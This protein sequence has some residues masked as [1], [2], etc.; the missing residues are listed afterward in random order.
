VN[1]STRCNLHY[2]R[3]NTKSFLIS[4]CSHHH[5]LSEI[6]GSSNITILPSTY[7]TSSLSSSFDAGLIRNRA[8]K[9]AIDTTQRFVLQHGAAGSLFRRATKFYYVSGTGQTKYCQLSTTFELKKGQLW[10]DGQ[11]IST[12]KGQNYAMFA[13]ISPVGKINK[14]FSIVNGKLQWKNAAFSGGAASFC[15][16]P[17]NTLVSVFKKSK[18]PKNCKALVLSKVPRTFA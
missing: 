12:S 8:A 4:I 1:W 5:R 14:G 15:I 18:Q 16:L 11:V 17:S 10:A 6:A 7:A 3:K 13:P 2:L 9:K